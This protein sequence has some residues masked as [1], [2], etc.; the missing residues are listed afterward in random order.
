VSFKRRGQQ[1]PGEN[2]YVK[3]PHHWLRDWR[4][5]GN[6]KA[7]LGYWI[8]HDEAYEV[9]MIQTLAEFNEG[10]RA[11]YAAIELLISL[12]YVERYQEH[13]GG[14]RG[15]G[16]GQVRY[17]LGPA[18]F[19]QQYVRNW[20]ASDPK[21]HRPRRDG[22]KAPARAVGDVSA[23]PSA[24]TFRG[25]TKRART[26]GGTKKNNPSEEQ[27]KEDQSNP[28]P[29]TEGAERTARNARGRSSA[30]PPRTDDSPSTSGSR[31]TASPTALALLAQL[32]R[33]WHEVA[34]WL[35]LRLG[36]KLDEYMAEPHGYGPQ[37]IRRAVEAY[38]PNPVKV[39]DG[40]QNPDKVQHLTALTRAVKILA[41]DVAAGA[42]RACGTEHDPDGCEPPAP[43]ESSATLLHLVPGACIRCDSTE[44][45]P[46]EDAAGA[47]VCD[48]CWE[49]VAAGG[50]I[51]EAA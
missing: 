51:G 24:S 36:V 40:R 2:F 17:D 5:T 30:A 45:T 15:K 39:S 4:L 11:L 47:F 7:V 48:P 19:E 50:S 14:G 26:K 43:V 44:A 49:I 12:G 3:V 18:A 20:G 46:R 21:D 29:G 10:E 6:A 31:S 23:G 38:A 37:A 41:I 16:F 13:H 27:P 25:S 42:C 9:T 35:R 22:T 32:P 34:P 33:P 8:G 28:P 1:L